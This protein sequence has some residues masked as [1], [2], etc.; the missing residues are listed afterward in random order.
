MV[1]YPHYSFSQNYLSALGTSKNPL[2]FIFNSSVIITAILLIPTYYAIYKI[3]KR[4]IMMQDI[5]FLNFSF[6]LAILSSL[7]LLLVGLIPANPQTLIPH[8]IAAGLFFLSIG[9]YYVIITFL[10]LKVLHFCANYKRFTSIWDYLGFSIIILV[11]IFID[12]NTWYNKL[13]Q[14]TIVYGSL[15]LLIYVSNKLR[16][17]DRDES[18]IIP[19][20]R[21]SP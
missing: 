1:T 12:L 9:F 2:S 19:K 10:M 17:I 4:N 21:E 8:L 13:I 20:P 6:G 14:K 5:K 16:K 15:L 3:M 11:L 18:C 7:S